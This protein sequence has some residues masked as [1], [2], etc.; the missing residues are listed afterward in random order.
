MTPCRFSVK[1]LGRSEEIDKR[2]AIGAGDFAHGFG[3]LAQVGVIGRGIGQV[4]VESLF[5]GEG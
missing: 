3:V 1:L 5:V 4:R 2:H